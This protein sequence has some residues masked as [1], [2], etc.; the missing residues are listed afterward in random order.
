MSRALTRRP[1]TPPLAPKE[2]NHFR[3][4]VADAKGTIFFMKVR[5]RVLATVGGLGGVVGI[6]KY[7]VQH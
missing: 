7:L 3:V 2:E 4:L 5:Y 1:S 6:V